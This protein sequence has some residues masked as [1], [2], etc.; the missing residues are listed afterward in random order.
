MEAAEVGEA[1]EEE[2]HWRGVT[3]RGS[4]SEAVV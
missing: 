2:E 1:C 4:E 3:L